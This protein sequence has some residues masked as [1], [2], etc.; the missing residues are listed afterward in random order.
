[1]VGVA[2]RIELGLGHTGGRMANQPGRR[3]DHAMSDRS[4]QCWLMAMAGFVAA[5]F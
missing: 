1:M 2:Y 4:D 3:E 5:K